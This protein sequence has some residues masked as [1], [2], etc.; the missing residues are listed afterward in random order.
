MNALPM[1]N[2]ATFDDLL[3]LPE[4][5]RNEL[6]DGVIVCQ[7]SPRLPH[8]AGQGALYK[9]LCRSFHEGDGGPEDPGGWVF[10]LQP[11]L[12]LGRNAFIPDIAAWRLPRNPQPSPTYYTELT[13]D[14]VC[15]LLSP[16]T[17]RMDRLRKFD[18]YAQAGVAHYW[19]VNPDLQTLEVY[20]LDGACYKRVASTEGSELGCFQPFDAVAL[21]LARCWL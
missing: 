12:H 2:E 10:L 8:Q 5:E 17:E 16:S 20:A 14:W 7:A 13:P 15:E 1:I 18:L 6:I 9:R 21:D 4:H 19:I 11:E 3:A